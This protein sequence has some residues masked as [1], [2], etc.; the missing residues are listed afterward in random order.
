MAK[1]HSVGGETVLGNLTVL[2]ATVLSGALTLVG[3]A[4][5]AASAA[6]SGALTVD[7][8][9]TLN[10]AIN[11]VGQTVTTLPLDLQT[12]TV[13]TVPAAASH[14]G[15]LIYVSD[16]AAGNPIVAF[17]DGTNWL[18]CDTAAAIAAA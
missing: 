17:S 18:R 14:T 8:A 5:T 9:A 10:G 13:A 16:G 4:I 2:G 3:Q 12:Y 11:L 7:G 1:V 15:R 6:L